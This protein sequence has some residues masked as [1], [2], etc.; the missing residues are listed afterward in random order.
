M[1]ST[2]SAWSQPTTTGPC[3]A[4]RTRTRICMTDPSVNNNLP[5]CNGTCVLDTMDQPDV[6]PVGTARCDI[7]GNSTGML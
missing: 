5:T 1:W 7:N 6:Q 2:W 4:T 3:L